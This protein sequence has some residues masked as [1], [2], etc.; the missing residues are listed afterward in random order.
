MGAGHG[1][2]LPVPGNAYAVMASVIASA[3]RTARSLSR[4]S[5]RTTPLAGTEVAATGRTIP[6]ARALRRKAGVRISAAPSSSSLVLAPRCNRAPPGRDTSAFVRA[7]AGLGYCNATDAIVTLSRSGTIACRVE[8][9]AE[10]H[11]RWRRD[12]RHG[13]TIPRARAL[14]RKAG[15]RTSAAPSSSS[16]V[17]A[18]R[19]KRGRPG[20]P[21]DCFSSVARS[22]RAIATPR[23]RSSP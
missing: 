8:A 6:R 2:R 16:L 20:A 4:G 15:V 23:M 17:L 7:S 11:P 14:R 18:P 1:M 19:S 9:R 22:A 3:T 5:T 12:R 10:P 13:R 21:R